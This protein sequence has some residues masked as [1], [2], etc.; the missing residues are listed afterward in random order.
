MSQQTSLVD[1]LETSGG[2]FEAI[3]PDGARR[4]I[5]GMGQL[6]VLPEGGSFDMFVDGAFW[7]NTTSEWMQTGTASFG[8]ELMQASIR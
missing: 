6:N 3:A 1:S 2:V 7:M 5:G 4:A 8:V